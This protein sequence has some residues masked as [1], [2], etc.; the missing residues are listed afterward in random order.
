MTLKQRLALLALTVAVLGSLAYTGGTA[1]YL[2]SN[3]Y[4]ESCAAVLSEQ[5]QLPSEIGRV[6]PRSRKSQE[7]RDVVVYLPQRRGKAHV[8]KS[9]LLTYAPT[10]RDPDAYELELRGGSS[11]ISMRT[12]LRMDLRSVLESGLR[13][14]LAPGGPSRV[15]F[16]GMN[17]SFE[18]DRFHADLRDASGFVV[19]DETDRGSA[20]VTCHEFNGY[21]TAE[22]VTLTTRFSA[23]DHGVRIDAMTLDVPE[24]PLRVPRL[25]ELFGARITSGQFRGRLLYEETDE[26]RRGTVAGRATEVDLAECTYG[27]LPL[28]IRGRVPELTLSDLVIQNRVPVHGA[29][30]GRATGV[31]IGDLLRL[32]DV[33]GAG[34]TA[35][36][37]VGVAEFTLDGIERFVASGTCSGISLEA[38][39][40]A[41]GWGKIAGEATIRLTDL[42]I[43]KNRL[44]SLRAS[45][46]VAGDESDDR[47]VDGELLRQIV[48][49]AMKFDL[50]R[51]L[52]ERIGY[53]HLGVRLEVNDER[54]TV[55][56]SHGQRGDVI[57]SARLFGAEVP[58]IPEPKESYDLS[59][60]LDQVRAAASRAVAERFAASQPASR[61]S[62]PP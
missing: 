50:P 14:G 22:P 17:L 13:P 34:G 48:S 24:L 18:R 21:R 20:T 5:L 10:D 35:T 32:L 12:W 42:T 60:W 49:R 9:A 61:R 55:F 1:W 8:C 43:E 4:R 7:F 58:L 37:D 31:R 46:D 51:I 28:P 44:R 25:E 3:A 2:R 27:L 26:G 39:S 29:L 59:P 52:P 11:E 6:V 23:H 45:I 15:R 38:V 16:S 57:L 53:T 56:G 47:W 30:R 62:D 54:L 41:I 40:E 33:E 19:F 36:L